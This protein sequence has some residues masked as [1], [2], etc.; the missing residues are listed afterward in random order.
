[1]RCV[2]VDDER[3]FAERLK[4]TVQNYIMKKGGVAIVKCL[5]AYSLLN[6]LTEGENY[7]L[8]LID[9]EMPGIGGLQLADKIRKIDSSAR[10]IFVTSHEKYA[11][12]S[13]KFRAYYYILKT[14]YEEELPLIL[15]SVWKELNIEPEAHYEIENGLNHFR[16]P[17]SNIIYIEKRQ[18]YTIFHCRDNITY[19]ERRTLTEVYENLPQEHF[20]M[21]DRGCVINLAYVGALT[22][23]EVAMKNGKKLAISR[24]MSPMVRE[25]YTR[26]W[27]GKECE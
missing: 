4:E 5:D 7:D 20:T 27:R 2:V 3:F 15:E 22:R 23:Y 18:K 16:V 10:V 14:E 25:D 6:M 26:F 17:L 13:I 21:I 12:K 9:I 1:M 11:L 24:G 8:Y 19:K